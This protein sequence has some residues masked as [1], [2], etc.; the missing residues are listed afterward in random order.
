MMRASRIGRCP[1]PE[2]N[3]P[4]ALSRSRRFGVSMLIIRQLERAVVD[5]DAGLGAQYLVG[6]N[7]L[8]GRHMHWRHEPAR[9]VCSDR[10][11]RQARRAE[12]LADLR[13]VIAESRVAREINDAGRP[14]RSRSRTTESDCGR[15][16]RAPKNAWPAR[17]EWWFARA[18]AIRPNP[19]R[20]RDRCPG[21]ATAA[22]RRA[23]R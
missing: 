11:Q 20:G 18:A 8:I 17:S 19:V 14:L 1:A 15:R 10:Q 5:R 3:R 16:V 23:E 22:L 4:G 21:I 7:R 2:T 12:P 13:E 9:L 6:S